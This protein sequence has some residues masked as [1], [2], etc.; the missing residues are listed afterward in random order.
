[1]SN[2][3]ELKKTIGFG[4]ALATVAG[5]VIGAGVFFKASAVTEYTGSSS[6]AMWSWILGGLITICAG[7]TVAELAA[8]YPETGGLTR[9]ITKSYGKFWGYLAGWAQTVVY[10]PANIAAIAIAF[11][12]QVVN[13]F[14]LS[15]LYIV[16]I[17]ALCALSLYLINFISIKAAGRV[18]SI[19]FICKL[20]PIIA[21][22]ILGFFH[23]ETGNVSLFPIVAGADRSFWSAL[24]QG[25]LATMFAYDGWLHVGNIAGEM[26]NP[27]RDLPLAISIGIA[28]VM[29]VYV[30]VNGVFYWIQPVNNIIGNMNIASDVSQI[31][32]G[33]FGGKI[34]TIGI[35]IS[36]YGGLNGYIMTGM[37]VPYVMGYQKQLPFSN[38]FAK[39][40][41]AGVPV[42]A[43]ICQFF[44]AV[45]MMLSGQFD[46]ITNML[47][48][49]IWFFYTM[50]FTAVIRLRRL[51]PDIERPYRVPLY[52][53]IPIVAILGGALIV[54]NT[55]FTQL[56][57]SLIGLLI[58]V[59]GI[60][61]Y[62]YVQ[63]K[64][65]SN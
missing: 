19:A 62:L 56:V 54:I 16:P 14:A 1:M 59:I 27:K 22:V 8:M 51:E 18:T 52:P 6:L 12:T 55:I 31:I 4:T 45:I 38:H 29:V 46:T 50:A 30:A 32:F 10:F 7:L 5:T 3:K 28:L 36:V 11:G 40:N 48:F 26:K 49:V 2:N 13:L 41:D 43:G 24:G 47:V 53:I 21:I 15:N 37:R 23:K 17:S 65:E 25:L 63:K 34:I 39:L 58:T 44:I 57:I 20:I 61:I 64:N 60:P 35:L 42:I 9:Y 33:D